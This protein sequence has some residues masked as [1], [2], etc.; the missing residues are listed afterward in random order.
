MARYDVF[1]ASSLADTEKA[2]L[3]VRRLRAL[4]FKVRYDKGRDHTTPTPRDYRDADNSQTILV[5]WSKSACDTSQAD[6]DWVHAIAHHARS[7]SGVLLQAG[8]DAAVP[9]DPFADDQRYML[10]GMGPRKLVDGYYQLTEELGRR[11]GRSDLKDWLMLKASDK[12]GKEI[13]KENHP[14]DPLSQSAKGKPVAPAVAA[15]SAPHSGAPTR[16]V[17]PP[18]TQSQLNPPRAPTQSDDVLGRI[19]LLAVGLVIAL[20]FLM[21]LL[22]NSQQMSGPQARVTGPTLLAQCPPGRDIVG[23]NHLALAKGA[24]DARALPDQSGSKAADEIRRLQGCL[25][26]IDCRSGLVGHLLLQSRLSAI[27]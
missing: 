6:S 11:D 13:W 22:M 8:L 24:G 19:I 18:I 15:A 20:M 5:L 26:M 17:I 12:D 9:D 3:I 14:T 21:S 4:K 25:E 1:L 10:S 2:Q 16:T 7:K 23:V 27:I